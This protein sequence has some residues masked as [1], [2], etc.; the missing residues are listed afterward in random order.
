ML[1]VTVDVLEVDDHVQG[2]GQHQQQNQRCDQ[3]HQ[4][5]RGEEGRAVAG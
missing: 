5:G 1:F 3:T 2:V 4:D